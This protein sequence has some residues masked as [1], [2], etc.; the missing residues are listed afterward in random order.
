[1]KMLLGGWLLLPVA[2]AAIVL[3]VAFTGATWAL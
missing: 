1:M 2:M 3:L